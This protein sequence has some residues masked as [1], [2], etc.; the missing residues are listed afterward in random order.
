MLKTIVATFQT[1]MG[2]SLS[3]QSAVDTISQWRAKPTHEL[4]FDSGLRDVS[5]Y[6][7]A[8]DR[9]HHQSSSN[10]KSFNNELISIA[11]ARLKHE[12]ASVLRRQSDHQRGPIS[13]TTESSFTTDSTAY[14]FRYEEYVAYEPPSQDVVDYLRNIAQRMSSNGNL[15]ECVEIYKNVRKGFL[16]THLKRLRFDELSL[17]LNSKRYVWDELRLKME[18][19]VQVCKICVKILFERE[20]K[21]CDQIF[22]GLDSNLAK[23]ECFLGTVQEFAIHLFNFVEAISLSNHSYERMENILGVY[24]SFMLVL[25][26]ANALFDCELGKEV[27]IK[28]AEIS[29]KIENDVLRLL[30]DFEKTV[31]LERSSFSDDRGAVHRSTVYAMDQIV[32]IAKNRE[33][34][35][36]LI[37]SAPSL[38]F[39][40]ITVRQDDLGDI[41]RRS[42]LDQHLILIIVVLQMNLKTKCENYKNATLGQLFMM[43]NVRYIVKRINEGSNGLREMIGESYMRKLDESFRLSMDNYRAL[44]RG[45]FLACFEDKGL[46]ITGCFKKSRLSKKAVK[47]RV[48]DFNTA[49]E[50]LKD[51]HSQWMVSDLE[52]RDELRVALC[53][54][55]VPAYVDFLEKLRSDSEINLLLE[56]NIKYSVK[57]FDA[58]ILETLFEDTEINV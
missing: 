36:N 21:L 30:Y 49:Y 32:I 23:D 27:R 34:L 25:P 53:G 52:L 39:G 14:L 58:L 22:Q 3:Q 37:K 41:N 38:N 28:C 31:L 43:N 19:W 55:L 8:V 45:K 35:A 57:D 12:F 13:T 54:D 47:R 50:E 5:H 48:K 40:Y 16:Q 2:S 4:I 10:L 46:Y 11:M 1:V 44:T 51:L 15:K 7:E 33:L 20:K 9:L 24:S 42:F 26:H 6:F 18:L 29:S 17:G 56:N